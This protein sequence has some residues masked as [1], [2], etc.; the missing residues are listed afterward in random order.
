MTGPQS[1]WSEL[2]SRL[3]A[4]ALKLKMHLA[5]SHDEEEVAE[6][7]GKLRQNMQDAIEAAG[8]AVKDEAVRSDVR[9]VGKL[10]ADAVSTT[11][12]K[13][14]DEIRETFPRKP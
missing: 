6:A 7:L 5:Q 14:T 9:E 1:T 8:T 10:L 11:L 13:V 12:T 4:L 2:A 3:E